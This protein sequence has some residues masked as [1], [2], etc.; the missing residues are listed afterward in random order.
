[1]NNTS[2]FNEAELIR[3]L[4]LGSQKAFDIIY[5]MYFRRLYT[6]CFKFVKSEEDAEEIVQDVFLRLWKMRMEIRQEETLQSLLFII[7]KSYLIKA[8]HRRINSQIFED[9]IEYK[10][11]LSSDE[12]TD[13]IIEYEEYLKMIKNELGKLSK[14]Q[15]KVIELAKI[16]QY[17]ISDTAK[18]LSLSEQTVRNQLSIGLRT[19]KLLMSKNVTILLFLLRMIVK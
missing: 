5:K 11:R 6:Y 13:S 2:F 18:C 9:Y 19:L 16:Q 7:S 4:K 15:R 1:M 12:E 8:F 10:E 14:T 17:S 3:E